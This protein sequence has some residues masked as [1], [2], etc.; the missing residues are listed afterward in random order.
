MAAY[1][2]LG[3]ESEMLVSA[4]SSVHPIDGVASALSGTIDVD[5]ADGR[6]RE[7]FKGRLE[8]PI[9]GLRSGNGLYDA[10]LQRRVDSRRHPLLVGE[11]RSASPANKDGLFNVEGDVT[12]H[13]ATRPVTGTLTMHAGEDGRVVLEGEH[14]FDVRDFDVRPPRILMLRVHP[15]VTVRIRLVAEPATGSR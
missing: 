2:I 3:G 12:F 14:V 7:L 8:V 9:D 6:V 11:V 1:R 4:T 13:G 5:I 10:E 15:N